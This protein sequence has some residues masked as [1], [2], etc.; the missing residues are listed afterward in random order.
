MLILAPM[1]ENGIDIIG[2]IGTS[3]TMGTYE[4]GPI[5]NQYMIGA[6]DH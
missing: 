5:M 3:I 1:M 4:T 2:K 6:G